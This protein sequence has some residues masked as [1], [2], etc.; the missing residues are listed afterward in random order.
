M[1]ID[2]FSSIVG[3][4][5]IGY[6]GFA[7]R[8]FNFGLDIMAKCVTPRFYVAEIVRQMYAI[9]VKSLLLTSTAA[10][11]VGIVLSMQTIGTLKTF[12]AINYVA[13]VVGLAMVKELGPV[14]TALMVAARA[15]SGITAELGAM[16]VTRQIDAL[17]VSSVNPVRFL[18]VTRFVACILTLPLLAIVSDILGILGGMIIGVQQGGM[19]FHLYLSYT[20]QYIKLADILPG[21]LK[22]VFFGMEV[23]IVASYYGFE[24]GG[25]TSGVGNSTQASVVTTSLFILVSDVI[26]TRIFILIFGG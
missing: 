11:S 25:G 2:R 20:L 4:R 8:M 23:G 24:A 7:G 21:L 1:K 12:G 16:K 13:V 22:T 26:L 19:G 17:T 6:A 18:A 9:G 15:G 14:L 3:A 5:V 10:F